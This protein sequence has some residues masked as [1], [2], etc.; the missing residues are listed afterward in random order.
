MS[1]NIHGLFF[2]CLLSAFV[3]NNLFK[4]V[5]IENNLGKYRI[6]D[7]PLP[8]PSLPQSRGKICLLPKII[9]MIS[10]FGAKVG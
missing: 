9:K 4:Y 1:N 3:W 5:Y 7:P 6:S 8:S 10:F 2:L